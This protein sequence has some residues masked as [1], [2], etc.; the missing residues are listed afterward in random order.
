MRTLFAWRCLSPCAMFRQTFNMF[1][2]TSSVT[3]EFLASHLWRV[4]SQ[5]SITIMGPRNA[6]AFNQDVGKMKLSEIKSIFIICNCKPNIADESE[7]WNHHWSKSNYHA[8]RVSLKC[9]TSTKLWTKSEKLYRWTDHRP[10]NCQG[11]RSWQLSKKNNVACY[12]IYARFSI[13]LSWFF[14]IFG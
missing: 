4:N 12:R 5:Y 6:N 1:F 13:K 9:S 11:S 2:K 3:G 7:V 14:F 10:T 8:W